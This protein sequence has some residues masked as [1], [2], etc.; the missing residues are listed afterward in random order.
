MGDPPP[1]PRRTPGGALPPHLARPRHPGSNG[2]AARPVPGLMPQAWSELDEEDD[3]RL[4]AE[5]TAFRRVAEIGPELQVHRSLRPSRAAIIGVL[6]VAAV[7][8][9][10]VVAYRM[11]PP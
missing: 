4:A 2:H 1:T 5:R 11:A 9:L 10:A 3:A 7:I 6:L 8:V